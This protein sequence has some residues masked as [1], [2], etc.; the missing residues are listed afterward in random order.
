MVTLLPPNEYIHHALCNEVN[1]ETTF[2]YL[3]EFVYRGLANRRP[4]SMD[5]IPGAE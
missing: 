3:L 2:K 4:G 5:Q 1:L